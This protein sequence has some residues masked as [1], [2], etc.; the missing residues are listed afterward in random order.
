M[1]DTHRDMRV[2]NGEFDALIQA[3]EGAPDEF[4][5]PKAEHEELLG[6]LLPVTSSS[7]SIPPPVPVSAASC[8]S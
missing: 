4:N 5:V 3:L 8:A 6:L 2:T 7:R 1:R